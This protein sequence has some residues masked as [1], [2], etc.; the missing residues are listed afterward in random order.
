MAELFLVDLTLGSLGMSIMMWNSFKSWERTDAQE[1]VLSATPHIHTLKLTQ[2]D[3][4]TPKAS[5]SQIKA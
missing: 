4:N 1:E 2:R 3:F 5:F